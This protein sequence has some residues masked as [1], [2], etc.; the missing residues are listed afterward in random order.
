LQTISAYGKYRFDIQMANALF[1]RRAMNIKKLDIAI[2]FGND[3][4]EILRLIC[5]N[6]SNL[7]ILYLNCKSLGSVEQV[8]KLKDLKLLLVKSKIESLFDSRD[9]NKKKLISIRRLNL[10]RILN[11]SPKTITNIKILFPN[12]Q[13]LILGFNAKNC[14][15]HE[16][17]EFCEVCHKQ[18]IH[19][20]SIMNQSLSDVKKSYITFGPDYLNKD[21]LYKCLM[22]EYLNYGLNFEIE[23]RH[24]YHNFDG[25]T[26]FLFTVST[27][28]RTERP[29][30][31]LIFKIDSYIESEL[32]I[33]MDYRLI[34][35]NVR[36]DI[37]D[38]VYDL[39]KDNRNNYIPSVH[40]IHLKHLKRRNEKNANRN[41]YSTVLV[42]LGVKNKFRKRLNSVIWLFEYRGYS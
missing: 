29:N 13:R 40:F 39:D 22:N 6:L 24:K 25:I 8:F 27:I 19:L 30:Q 31:T 36:F 9:E 15:S 42:H 17:I 10:R 33:K 12:I 28:F 41:K 2:S 23:L 1:T 5:D 20:F 16:N 35:S 37:V 11:I 18:C 7:Q 14:I 34:H 38:N 26:E 4:K 21:M 3:S 32:N